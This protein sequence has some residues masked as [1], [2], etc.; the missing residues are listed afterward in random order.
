MQLTY[1]VRHGEVPDALRTYAEDEVRGLSKYFERLV[2]G[3]IILDRQNHRHLAEV[4]VHTSTDTHFASTEA[5]DW[6]TA[7]DGT[8]AKLARQL[9]RHKRKLNSRSLSREE[10][11]RLFGPPTDGDTAVESGVPPRDW[12]RISSREAVARLETSGEEVLVFVDSRDGAVKIARREEDGSASVVEA[13]RF[14]VEEA[15]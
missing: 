13:E 7:I 1:S 10:R 3:D 5:D 8:I 14:E 6:R 9:K 15:P 2:E 12:D 4:R 11:A